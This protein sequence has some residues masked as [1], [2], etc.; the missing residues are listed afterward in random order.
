MQLKR[1]GGARAY[2]SFVCVML[3]AAIVAVQAAHAQETPVSF[4]V[5]RQ[6]ASEGILEFAEQAQVS[7]LF[8]R[9]LVGPH[10]TNEVRGSYSIED[11]LVVLLTETGLKGRLTDTGTLII[12]RCDKRVD[13]EGNDGMKTNIKR[14]TFRTAFLTS[15]AA[16]ASIL[17]AGA[18]AQ[19]EERTVAA[20]DILIVTG[21]RGAPRSVIDSPIPIDVF[22]SEMLER[23]PATGGLFEQLRYNVPS[24]NLPQRAGGG[25]ATFIA[26]AGLRALNPDQTLV[27]VN[28][29]RRHKTSLINTSTGLFSGSA[30]VDL[31]M[32]P[33]S[34]IDRVEVLR[35]GAAAQYGSD[36]I[37]GVVNIILKEAPEGGFLTAT[38]GQNFDRNDGEFLNFGANAGF[39]LG[40]NGF[41]NLSFDYRENEGSERASPV[42]VPTEPG[43]PFR[44][45][46]DVDNGDGTFSVDPRESLVNR[47]VR[48]FGEYPSERYSFA[49][50]AAYDFGGVEAYS[51][52]TYTDRS[53]TLFFT[54]RR[55]RDARNNGE[56]FPNGFIP[57]EEIREDDYEVVA[58]LRGTTYGFDWDLSGGYGRNIADW[59]NNLGANASL[60]EFSPTSFFLGTFEV[61]E[62]YAQFDATRSY[63]I[64]RG[65]LQVSFGAQFRNEEFS[66]SE[67]DP[68]G[69]LTFDSPLVVLPNDP[70]G[71]QGFPAFGPEDVNSESRDNFGF[72]GELGWQ[73]SP[74][75][76][77]SAAGR[78]E[79]YSDASGDQ[80]I[81]K[82]AGRYDPIDWLGLRASVNTGFRAPS[83]QQLGFK[84]SRGQFVDLDNDSIAET[85]VLRQT[86]PATDPAAQA[87]GASPLDP[88]TSTN[89]SAGFTFNPG[90]GLTL[91]VDAYQIDI[92]DRIVLSAQFNR[93]DNRAALGG[94]TIG[95][96][97]SILLD[98][99]GIGPSIDGANYFT[100]AIDTRSRGVDVVATYRVPTDFGDFAFNGAFNYNDIDISSIDD[101]P[102]EL[103]ALVLADGE[104]LQ[105]FDRARLGTY[106]DE[107]PSTKLV[108]STNYTKGPIGFLVRA[109]RFG[110]YENVTNNPAADTFNPAKFIFDV[111]LTYEFENGFSIAAGSNN[112]ANTYPDVVRAEGNFGGGQYDT[113]SPFGFT[114]GNWFI[115][116]RYDW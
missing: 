83:V 53:S 46:P 61:K 8:E 22:S 72:Y 68:E 67:G 57:E 71:A 59:H 29:K 32:I 40:E 64:S 113:N 77:I 55:P 50:N 25:T 5:D 103:A 102:E 23:I 12:G 42:P 41:V 90:N 76:F 54:F 33:N 36:A 69:T 82:V 98:D 52:A 6:K 17:P 73:A 101:N 20:E 65:E 80:A 99:A 95:D 1:V 91:T 19:D 13:V 39:A 93:G 31:N 45:Y 9:K 97:V 62:L 44:F 81:F 106:T 88:E 15:A 84:G 43:A 63:D 34:A 38:R 7:V 104:P 35:D 21:V 115:T 107:I 56:I 49:I 18:S 14:G 108:L 30:G 11:A 24:L 74:D 48:N 109:T 75:F 116:G 60:G 47:T 28:G 16:L 10:Y 89:F 110:S 66:I 85:I 37:A 2:V 96:Q 26:S 100:N 114:G 94:G 111:Q 27:L 79:N 78:Y 86:L 87:L 105:Q 58:G 92:D 70:R 3:A 51:F 4:Q 112:I